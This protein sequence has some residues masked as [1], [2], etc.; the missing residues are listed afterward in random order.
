MAVSLRDLQQRGNGRG[1]QPRTQKAK[2]YQFRQWKTLNL[3]DARASIEDSELSWC[4][5]A[6]PI[7]NG[8]IQILNGPGASIATIA[9]GIASLWGVPFS[10]GGVFVS[11]NSDGSISKITTGGVVTVVAAA[12]TVTTAARLS[13]WQGSTALIIDPTKGYFSYDG[14]TF[15]LISAGQTGDA[16]TVFE[17]RAWISKQR[18]ISYTAPNTFN[19]FTAGNGAGSTIIT[20]EAFP[21]NVVALASTLEALWIVGQGG[22]EQ[23]ANVTASGVA[24][25]VITSFSITNIV[26]DLGSNAPNSVIPYFRALA[27]FAPFGPW[28]LSGVT[29]QPL[30]EK[31]D[32][33]IPQLTLTPDVPA[34]VAVVQNLLCLLFLV[35]YTGSQAQAG[36]GPIPIVIGF[37]KGKVFLASQGVTLKWITTLIVNGVAQAWGADTAGHIFQL[38]GASNAT[39]VVYRVQSKLFDF[40]LSTTMKAA[41]KVGFEF[42]SPNGV[43]N[44]TVTVDSEFATQTVAIS[45]VDTITF[46]NAAGAQIQFVNALGNPV[47]FV[48]QATVLARANANMWGHYL[49]I[50]VAGTDVPFRIQALQMEVVQSREWSYP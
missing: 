27:L 43:V 17:G 41:Y 8:A 29:P 10:S 49:G 9:Q 2:T 35:T 7:G 14:T 11:I 39:P 34:A 45:A 1:R 26:S 32:G 42:Q 24:P 15:T 4:E 36:A 28:V 40:G 37:T 46:L 31:L 44:P 13:M 3:T 21:G 12:G 6:L 30:T 48:T 19:D 23:L 25:N 22:I 47:T 50:T 33:L 20:D 18:T 38:F 16:V 5:N